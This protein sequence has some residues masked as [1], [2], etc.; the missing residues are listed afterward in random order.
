MGLINTPL[1]LSNPRRPDIAPVEVVALADTGS[2]HLSIPEA[3]RIQLMLEEKHRKEI[4][5]VDGTMKSVP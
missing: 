5:L 2:V 3:V 1:L 4:T